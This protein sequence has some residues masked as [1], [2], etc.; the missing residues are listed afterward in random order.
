MGRPVA[1]LLVL[2]FISVT[3]RAAAFRVHGRLLADAATEGGAVVPIHWTQA[4]NYV[5]NFTIGTPP[6]PASAVIDLAGELV[7]TQC[8]QCS[9][10]FE[11]DTPLFDPTA[12]NT[13]RAEPCGTPLCE[14]IPSDSRN[15]SGNV[16]AYQASTNAGDTG[17][18]VGTDTFAV[19]TAKASLAFGCVVA[20]DID[21]MGGPSGIVGLGRTPWSLVTQTGV[22]A[23]SY[24]L[25]PHD[26]GRNS[27]LFLGSSAKLA[28]GGKAAS[29][30][31]VN[32]SGNGND[33]SNYYKV[34]LEG[35]E[36][37]RRDDPAAAERQH[38]SCSTPSRRSA[39]SST[40]LTRPV[41]KAVTGRRRRTAD[42]DAGG[43]VRPLLPEIGG[44]RRGA[45]P[46]VHVPGRRRHDGAGDELPARLQER[47]GVP[48][49]AEL[50][51]A[52]LD[53]GAELAG[54]LAAG[55]HP[56]PL[57]PR[58]GDALLRACRLH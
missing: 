49:H 22:A 58:Q 33:L 44:E 16:C 26:A 41:K 46:R 53:D 39:S 18:K 1:T 56:F 35:A 9:R 13:Y 10:C 19:G 25:A 52:E 28:G 57:R 5:A 7:W 21:T 20:S 31:F 50:G 55:E 2:C 32:I 17:G 15:C 12:S 38:P 37:R 42:G 54:K 8:K 14:S 30:P 3:A 43:A 23:F 27:A 40:A 4:M 24:C 11:Q 51:A 36:S 6:Q 45:G 29:T 47:H 34:Q 48:R